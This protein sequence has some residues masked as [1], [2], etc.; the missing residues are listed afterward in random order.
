MDRVAPQECADGRMVSTEGNGKNEVTRKEQQVGRACALLSSRAEHRLTASPGAVQAAI[1]KIKISKNIQE[2]N[3][4]KRNL[5]SYTV[6]NIS[7]TAMLASDF[8][9]IFS[10]QRAG[11]GL[12]AL[13]A[14]GAGV[15]CSI[16]P[17]QSRFSLV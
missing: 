4:P 12:P 7:I 8:F 14:S 6:C 3:S 5:R 9:T 13:T 16:E 10:A 2:T 11:K 17:E 15:I 1:S